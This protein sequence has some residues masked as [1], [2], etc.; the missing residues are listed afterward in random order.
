MPVAKAKAKMQSDADAQKKVDKRVETRDTRIPKSNSKV[1]SKD[2][3]QTIAATLE[4]AYE[5]LP[6]LYFGRGESALPMAV[7][8]ARY[9]TGSLMYGMHDFGEPVKIREAEVK[10]HFCRK[11][12]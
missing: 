7:E 12:K 2:L 6:H 1:P 11:H 4:G 10:M 8:T 9:I 5:D 3:V